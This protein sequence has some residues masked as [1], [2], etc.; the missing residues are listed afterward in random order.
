[1]RLPASIALIVASDNL[2]HCLSP[3]SNLFHRT[4]A[5]EDLRVGIALCRQ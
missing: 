1:L 5:C 2:S 4:F 3:T